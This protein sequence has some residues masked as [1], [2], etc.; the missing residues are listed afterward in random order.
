MRKKIYEEK[1]NYVGNWL[2]YCP[3][4]VCIGSRYRELYRDTG[5]GRHGLGAP[6]GATRS[7]GRAVARHDTTKM[8]HDT[9][10]RA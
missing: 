6:G 8:G 10:G 2:G 7:S 3:F 5:L 1:K 4:S 9:T